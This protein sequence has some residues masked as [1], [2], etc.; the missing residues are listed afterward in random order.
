MSTLEEAIQPSSTGVN[1]HYHLAPIEHMESFWDGL[2]L[3]IDNK[4]GSLAVVGSRVALPS[5]NSS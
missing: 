2:L 4:D 5:W 1:T 3:S